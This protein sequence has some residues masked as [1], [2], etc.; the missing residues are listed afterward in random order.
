VSKSSSIFVFF[1]SKVYNTRGLTLTVDFA[2][3]VLCNRLIRGNDGL[4]IGTDRDAPVTED[5][6]FGGCFFWAAN[7]V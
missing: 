3:S 4:A 2:E 6:I 1:S 5:G 7:R